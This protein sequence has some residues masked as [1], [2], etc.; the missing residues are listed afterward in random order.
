MGVRITGRRIV[1][2]L[3]VLLAVGGLAGAVGV[4]I[5]R[6]GRKAATTTRTRR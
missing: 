6:S 4:R 5:S 2:A 1:V 3:A